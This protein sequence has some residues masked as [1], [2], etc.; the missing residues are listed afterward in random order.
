MIKAFRRG[1][2]KGKTRK[3]WS[4]ARAIKAILAL[5]IAIAGVLFANDILRVLP[6][7]GLAPNAPRLT[8][9]VQPGDQ[10]RR[11]D[12]KHV[13]TGPSVPGTGDMPSRLLFEISDDTLSL[14]GVIAPGDADRFDT[15]LQTHDMPAI[16]TLQSTGGSVQDA[17]AIG[18]RLRQDAAN[19]QVTAGNVC[20]SACPYLFA[21]GTERQAHKDAYIGVHQHYFG[22]NIALPAFLAV[23]D[24]QRGQGEVMGYL[25]DMGIDLRLM[26]PALLT[27]PEDIYV[28]TPDELTKYNLAT[29]ITE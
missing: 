19:T 17:L 3:G 14:T 21:A 8:Q 13:P 7:L 1:K 10:T 25:D 27:P 9:P 29:E 5:Q 20:L 6:S 12:P 22:E 16:V 26:Q 11:Y 24:I 2:D 28:L 15:W 18:K 23:E 4:A